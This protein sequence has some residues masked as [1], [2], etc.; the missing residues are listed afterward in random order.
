MKVVYHQVILKSL[1]IDY[2]FL[3]II[4]TTHRSSGASPMQLIQQ[5]L[6]I[7][8]RSY[9]QPYEQLKKCE[10]DVIEMIEKQFSGQL[11]MI[12][13]QQPFANTLWL[14]HCTKTYSSWIHRADKLIKDLMDLN[15]SFKK[16]SLRFS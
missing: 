12:D 13:D 7:Y 11:G 5:S 6:R 3:L 9:L 10:L 2:L 8:L 15:E 16:V 4:A 1:M 14:S